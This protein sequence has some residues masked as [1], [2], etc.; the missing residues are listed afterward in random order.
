MCPQITFQGKVK[1]LEHPVANAIEA[2]QIDSNAAV[3]TLKLL[4]GS[5]LKESILLA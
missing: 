2:R 5:H 3:L 1:F 4:S